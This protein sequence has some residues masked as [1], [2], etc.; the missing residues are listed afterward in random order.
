LAAFVLRQ[1]PVVI[2]GIGKAYAWALAAAGMPTVL[3]MLRSG[4]GRVQQAVQRAS[5]AEVRRWFWAAMLLQVDGVTPDVAEALVDADVRSVE[6]LADAGLERLE[7]AVHQADLA[8]RLKDNPPSLYRL[9]AIQRAAALQRGTG[10]AAGRLIDGPTGQPIAGA[11]V[12]A[13]GRRDVTD[14]QGVFILA[15]LPPGR[16]RVRVE[17][18]GHLPL[19]ASVEVR[20]HEHHRFVSIRL[21]APPAARPLRPA[22]VEGDGRLIAWGRDRTVRLLHR[23]LGDIP[24]GAHLAVRRVLSSG[25]VRLLH[26]TRIQADRDIMATVVD[27]ARAA[28]PEGARIGEVLVWQAGQL[29]RAGVA[30]REI[31]R[32][33]LEAALGPQPLTVLMRRIKA[34]RREGGGTL[35]G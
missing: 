35:G 32:R 28:V 5:A 13:G 14:Q 6:E 2:E 8:R 10:I 21:P 1:S 12:R 22:L 34:G 24:D 3:E 11:V 26:L 23:P 17:A 30:R 18:P 7:R 31:G 29:A 9:G 15:R 25:A 4:P 27:V 33:V 16:T 19:S 20:A